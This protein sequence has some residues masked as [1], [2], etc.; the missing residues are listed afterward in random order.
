VPKQTFTLKDGSNAKIEVSW[1]PG[2]KGLN[3]A[4]RDF[5]VSY[6]GQVVGKEDDG[7]TA[8]KQPQEY[9]LP[10]GS[11]LQAQIR[12]PMMP[13]LYLTRNGEPVS[14]SAG[15]PVQSVK[16]GRV[17]LFI[18]GGINIVFGLIDVSPSTQTAAFIFGGLLIAFGLVSMRFA[19]IGLALGLLLFLI[20]SGLALASFGS[21]F[22]G[23]AVSFIFVRLFVLYILYTGVMAAWNARKA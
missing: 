13:T 21:G 11:K 17:L 1:R 2:M 16:N 5:T 6:N 14:G 22:G 18:F 10:D 19:L 4:W 23:T 3:V 20:D 15:D 9:K 12:N 8:L 7:L